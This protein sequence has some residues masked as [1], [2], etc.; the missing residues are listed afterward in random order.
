[1]PTLDEI[2]RIMTYC[3]EQQLFC[4]CLYHPPNSTNKPRA[5]R[6]GKVLW[7][8]KNGQPVDYRKGEEDERRSS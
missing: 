7:I 1:M 8:V 5:Q 3:E 4:N 6:R 2:D